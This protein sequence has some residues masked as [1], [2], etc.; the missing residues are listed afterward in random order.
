MVGRPTFTGTGEAVVLESSLGGCEG[1][2]E[3]F[4]QVVDH[5]AILSRPVIIGRGPAH[6]VDEMHARAGRT[7]QRDVCQAVIG[8]RVIVKPSLDALASGC[9]SIKYGSHGSSR[10]HPLDVLA[11]LLGG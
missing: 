8:R 5:A 6:P 10:S 4:D 3:R 9:A 1:D 7:L 11:R 2:K